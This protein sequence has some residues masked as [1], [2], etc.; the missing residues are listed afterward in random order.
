MKNYL[1]KNIFESIIVVQLM[2]VAVLLSLSNGCAAIQGMGDFDF[3]TAKATFE[4]ALVK[5]EEINNTVAELNIGG[6]GDSVVTWILA[7]ALS[8]LAAAGYYPMIG[9]KLRL[10][11]EAKVNGD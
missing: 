11:K 9:R 10:K 8:S 7:V 5:A 4:A 6:D 2:G 1:I 3:Q